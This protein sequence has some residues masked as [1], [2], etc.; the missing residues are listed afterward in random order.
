MTSTVHST[1]NTWTTG[2]SSSANDSVIYSNPRA[3]SNAIDSFS[4]AVPVSRVLAVAERRPTSRIRLCRI[5][6]RAATHAVHPGRVK[7]QSHHGSAAVLRRRPRCPRCRRG[8]SRVPEGP[9][10]LQLSQ[11]FQTAFKDSRPPEAGKAS[12]VLARRSRRV[13]LAGLRPS[14]ATSRHPDVPHSPRRVKLHLT[15]PTNPHHPRAR[16]IRPSPVP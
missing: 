1:R 8:F 7:D 6:A 4:P 13:T 12:A 15:E 3:R 14:L 11:V 2:R 10:S 16:P 5:R 9:K